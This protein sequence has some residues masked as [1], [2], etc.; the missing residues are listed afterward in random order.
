MCKKLMFLISLVMLLGL[1]GLAS[2]ADIAWDPAGVDD[3]W[4]TDDNWAGDVKPGPGDNAVVN[5]AGATPARGPIVNSVE[6]CDFVNGGPSGDMAIDIVSGGSLTVLHWEERWGEDPGGT[7]TF[8]FLGGSLTMLQEEG[9]STFRVANHGDVVM[10]ISGDFV[11]NNPGGARMG[12]NDDAT[13]EI[14]MDGGTLNFDD[15]LK[16]GDDGA[17]TANFSGGTLNIEWMNI[18]ARRELQT[19]N[20]SGDVDFNLEDEFLIG[21]NLDGGEAIVNM[22]GG[23]ID[24]DRLAMTEDDADRSGGDATLNMS[25]GEINVREVIFPWRNGYPGEYTINMLA[26]TGTINC[27]D[28]KVQDN[29]VLNCE[30]GMVNVGASTLTIRDGGMVNIASEDFVLCLAGDQTALV[31]ALEGAGKIGGYYDDMLGIFR[32]DIIV[33]YDGTNTCIKGVPPIYCQAFGPDPGDGASEIGSNCN[34]ILSWMTGDCVL[35]KGR[36]FIYF[37]TDED[38]VATCPGPPSPGPEYQGMNFAMDT[39]WDIGP[40]P[41]WQTFYW[42]VDQGCQDGS[43]CPGQVWSF[44]TGCELIGGDI[45]LDCLVNFLDYAQLAA[46][47]MDTQYF[48]DGCD[49]SQEDYCGP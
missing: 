46:T 23:T 16:L 32:G 45:N 7:A 20:I 9:D 24:A 6:Q 5:P 33:V 12:D 11:W 35:S 4:G 42:R 27:D 3:Y 44:T 28:L 14:N 19:I 47:W 15:C 49:P 13:F 26:G 17:G 30:G 38:A 40:L 22:S 10:N 41:L 29:G 34:I 1:A 8:N 43:I 48:P 37:G 21:E 25:G 31:A 39:D 36:H 18:V 2:A